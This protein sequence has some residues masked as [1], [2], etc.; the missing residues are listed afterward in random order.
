MHSACAQT[1]TVYQTN[2][3][4]S[5]L[6]AQQPSFTFGS[7]TS[8]A[9]TITIN[10]GVRYQ[11]M[12][13]FGGAFTDSST[14]LVYNKLTSAQQTSLLDSLFSTTG[15]IGLSFIRLPM[16]ASDFSA[17]G[18]F[19]YD[20]MPSGETDV[21]LA[22]F[23]LAKDMSYTIPVVQAALQVNPNLKIYMLPW[24]PPGWMKTS[25]TMNGGDFN[26][27]YYSSLANYFV[28]TIQGYQ[29]EGIPIYAVTPQNEPENSSGSYPSESLSSDEEATFIASYLGPALAANNLTTKIFDYDHNFTDITYPETV[30]EGTAYPYVA[31]TTW[32]CYSGGNVTTATQLH[33]EYPDKGNWLTECTGTAGNSFAGDLAWSME[34]Q[35]IGGPRNY[36]QSVLFWNLV[37]DQNYGPQNGGC[38]DCTPFITVDDST[39]PSTISYDET[40]YFI[41]QAS[42]FVSP[43]AW[44]IASNSAAPGSG[45]IEDVAFQNSN[46]SIALIVF[47]DAASSTPFNVVWGP[48]SEPFTYTLPAGA[49]A[50]FTWMPPVGTLPGSPSDLTATA[51]ASGS[52]INLSWT[53]SSTSA[54]TYNVYRSITSG[55]TPGSG[56]LIA[57]SL[58]GTSY[59]DTGLATSTTYYYVVSA[60][61]GNGYSSNSNQASATTAATTI[62][63]PSAY[64]VMI[65]AA[66]G[67]C[68]DDDGNTSNGTAVQQWQCGVGNT[69]QEWWLWSQND[70]YSVIGDYVTNATVWTVSGAGTTNGTPVV[71]GSWAYGNNQEWQPVEL[72]DG[73]YTF[74]DRNSGLCLNVPGGSNTNGIQLQIEACNGSS[75]ESFVMGAISNNIVSGASYV[76]VNQ[77]SGM[78]LTDTG[79]GTGNGTAL[80]QQTCGSLPDQIWQF[81][82]TSNGYYAAFNGNATSLVWD[83]TNGSLNNG[84]LIQLWSWANNSNQQWLPQLQ[85]NGMWTFTN[86]TSGSCLDNAGSTSSGTQMT[87]W[88]CQSGNTNQQFEL[89]RVQ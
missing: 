48:N 31:G 40:Y 84:N 89:L 46:G 20:D 1:V 39:S 23:S 53:A 82:P 19:S 68:V 26:T 70:E 38:G 13:G 76:V 86:L 32:H 6:L 7:S 79:S 87:Q 15:G 62:I 14:Y 71:Q 57:S 16:G 9:A 33:S 17:Q 88:A 74:V 51:S 77:T 78:C 24:S 66:S 28:K 85:S 75:S 47:N 41:G 63:A 80:D 8:G 36:G 67:S 25:G 2:P 72:S 35:I 12:D 21:D 60:A 43:G 4:Q 58:T 10:P 45:G 73:Y 5:L 30:L 64:Y 27:T 65:N 18:D 34:N 56:N 59:T 3:D 54:V 49:A 44:V 69:N 83:D 50:T 55:F 11:Q 37:L 42:K 81:W 61:N 52:Q 29:S 22:N